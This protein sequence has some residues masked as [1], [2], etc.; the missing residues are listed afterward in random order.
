MAVEARR[1]RIS[2]ATSCFNEEGNIPEWYARLKAVFA[3][4]N[5]YDWEIVIADN[6]STD[7]SR[8]I[9]RDLARRDRAFKVIFNANNFGYIRSPYNAFLQASG[10]AVV[11]MCCDLQEPPEVIGR[12]VEEWEKGFRVV[13]AVKPISRENPVMFGL[14]SFYYLLMKQL[15][16]TP[17]IRH[18]TNFGLYDRR[19]IEALRKYSE[20]YPYF[21]GLVTEIGFSRTEVTYTQE[22]R[23]SGES[24]SSL[25]KLYDYAMTGFVNHT[26]LPL[27]LAAFVGFVLAGL[28]F[29]SALFYFGYKLVFWNTFSL[30]VAPIVIGVFFIAG[31]QLIF[32]GIIG[33]YLGAV[34]TQVKNRPLVIEEERLNF[35]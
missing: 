9:L 28:C 10:D 3:K 19:F 23:H 1:K 34:W 31:V 27:R 6:C 22:R 8:E 24:K 5:A 21:R 25:P 20:P 18:F 17:Q 7:G 15:A 13:C 14:R 32:I 29:I 4:F 26:K 11:W 12:L 16:E 35:E 33:E 30:G 2:I